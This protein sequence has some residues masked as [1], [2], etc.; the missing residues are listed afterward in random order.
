MS[1]NLFNSAQV[2]SKW[3][4]GAWIG[5]VRRVFGTVVE[6][7]ESEVIENF[8]P[9][10]LVALWPPQTLQEPML[11][12]WP[13]LVLLRPANEHSLDPLLAAMPG[14][15]HLWMPDIEHDWAMLAEIVLLSEGH[16]LPWQQRRLQQFIQIERN[17]ARQRICNSYGDAGLQALRHS[18][19]NAKQA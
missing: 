16:L 4:P 2:V 6:M 19:A 9:H 3:T 12:R 15:A 11:R 18:M 8:G 14:S 13:E 7:G 10:E 17:Q 1:F 5:A